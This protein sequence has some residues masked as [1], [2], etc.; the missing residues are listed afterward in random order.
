M[1]PLLFSPFLRRE[2][3]R[4]NL[5]H[6]HT[7]PPHLLHSAVTSKGSVISA[8]TES[9]N[10]LLKRKSVKSAAEVQN[11]VKLSGE[12]PGGAVGSTLSTTVTVH[13]MMRLRCQFCLIVSCWTV[14]TAFKTFFNKIKAFTQTFNCSKFKWKKTELE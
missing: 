3:V 9:S 8:M 13:H 10:W 11:V 5:L 6:T 2:R 12:N 1:L 4:S 7:H 14:L